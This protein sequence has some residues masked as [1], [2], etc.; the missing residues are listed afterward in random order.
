MEPDSV[1]PVEIGTDAEVMASVEEGETDT[2][3]IADVS[4]DDAYLTLPLSEAAALP[5]WR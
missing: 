5:E 1:A 4:T 2:L 3:I